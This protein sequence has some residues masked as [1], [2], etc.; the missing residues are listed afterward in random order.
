MK[1]LAIIGLTLALTASL[2]ACGQ[3]EKPPSAPGSASGS[4]PAASQGVDAATSA[5]QVAGDRNPTAE[6]LG[7]EART[8]LSMELEGIPEKVPATLYIGQGYSIYIPDQGWRLDEPGEWE[9]TVNHDVELDVR[10]TPGKTAEEVR[11]AILR[12][13]DDYGFTDP[14][15]DGAFSGTDG[16]DGK[17]MEVR[18]TEAAGGVYAVT[19]TY[20]EEAVEGFGTRLAAIADSF[21]PMTPNE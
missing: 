17:I 1:R 14:D 8:D 10:F 4:V 9:S 7:R 5:T 12:E 21:A 11:A 19:W 6:E 3:T 20:P 15:P 16:E 13:E 2:T 18:L